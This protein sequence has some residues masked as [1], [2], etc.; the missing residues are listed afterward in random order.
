MSKK[1]WEITV[2]ERVFVE[3]ETAVEAMEG[4]G[5]DGKM[6]R[7]SQ[8]SISEVCDADVIEEVETR[9]WDLDALWEA[10][11]DKLPWEDAIS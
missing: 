4:C 10:N 7:A 6:M 3:A 8:V 5:L 1:L 11:K 9:G 2:T